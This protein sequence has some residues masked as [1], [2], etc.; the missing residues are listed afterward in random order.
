ML[1]KSSNQYSALLSSEL[2]HSRNAIVHARCQE[3]PKRYLKMQ[4]QQ[5]FL[6]ILYLY[7][8][9]TLILIQSYCCRQSLYC[10]IQLFY[11][12]SHK[13]SYWCKF[14]VDE[15]TWTFLMSR[16]TSYEV[17]QSLSNNMPVYVAYYADIYVWCLWLPIMLLLCQHNRLGPNVWP[18]LHWLSQMYR[19]SIKLTDNVVLS[20]H[21][22]LVLSSI[23]QSNLSVVATGTSS[24][25][26]ALSWKEHLMTFLNIF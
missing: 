20:N 17:W 13:I 16:T 21:F 9:K 18:L 1:D 2:W 24:H 5:I 6:N 22:C 8:Y 3:C 19:C 4:V 23:T 15:E 11:L 7:F 10:N 14:F 25:A 12:Q 26:P